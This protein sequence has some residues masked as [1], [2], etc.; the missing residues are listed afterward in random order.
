MWASLIIYFII[1]IDVPFATN[2][3]FDGYSTVGS[4]THH[5]NHYN[6]YRTF[7][8][9]YTVSGR[10]RR[11]TNYNAA[12]A[13]IQ[14]QTQIQMLRLLGKIRVGR[15]TARY[16]RLVGKRD[17]IYVEIKNF[18]SNKTATAVENGT[19]MERDIKRWEAERDAVKQWERR[20]GTVNYFPDF[21]HAWNPTLFKQVGVALALGTAGSFVGLGF[22]H[23]APYVALTSTALYWKIGLEDITQKSKYCL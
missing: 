8:Q 21:I 3:S 5:Y 20:M 18:T 13:F 10:N 14:L 1:N 17:C 22:F 11:N 12:I 16:A 2:F 9:L 4:T 7:N 19:S 15:E 6:H 23:A